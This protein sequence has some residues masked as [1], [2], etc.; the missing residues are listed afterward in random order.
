MTMEHYDVAVLGAGPAGAMAALEATRR[1][2]R[3]VLVEAADHVGG[4]AHSPEI[5]GV[6][7]DLGSHRL[8]PVVP[9]SV[10]QVLMPL[11]GDDLQERVRRGRIHMQGKWLKFPLELGDLARNLPPSF[12]AKTGWETLTGPFRWP[13]GDTAFDVIS[14]R[15]GPTVAAQFYLPYLTKLWDV[16][17][18]Q[19]SGELA[20]RRVAARGPGDILRKILSRNERPFDYYY[21]RRGFGQI[22][23]VLVDAATD[24]GATLRLSSPVSSLDRTNAT[25]TVTAGDDAFEATTVVS[26]LPAPLLARMAGAPDDVIAAGS[27]LRHR[28]MV[29]VY[30]VLDAP[31]LT[32]F[33]AH[34]FPELTTPVSRMNEPKN[35]RVSE[36][37]P[38]D[39]TVVCAEV[40]CWADDETFAAE[41]GVLADRVMSTLAPLGFQWPRLL[42][43]EVRRLPRVY[44]VYTGDYADDLASIE[45]WVED[46]PGLLTFGRQGLFVPDNTHHALLMG[47]EAAASVRDD[48]SIDHARW[49]RV[50]EE[51]R[52]H[53][54]ED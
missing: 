50:R 48:G 15:L 13:R 40:P 7:V 16:P 54:V 26:S 5:G 23:E 33:D 2:R 12:I 37:D 27:R 46:Q 30:L 11:L 14:A 31:Q 29:L 18:T 44:P 36:D 53:V 45:A 4:M 42:D 41:A 43:V 39:V 6:R 34:Y 9:P 32:P 25:T 21:P 20:D 38:S 24:E 28:A 49:D 51:F 10:E 17:P 47:Q 52:S 22:T 35:Y 1:G 8:H 19:L 3:T